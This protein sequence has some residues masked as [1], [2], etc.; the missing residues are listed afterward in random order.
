[1]IEFLVVFLLVFVLLSSTGVFVW[2]L[3]LH[4]RVTKL[5]ETQERNHHTLLESISSLRREIAKLRSG[6]EIQESPPFRPDT[7]TSPNI[8]AS[9][10]VKEIAS[11]LKS[12]ESAAWFDLEERLGANW[13]LKLGMAMVVIGIAL[14]L[15]YTFQRLGPAGK[16]LIGAVVSAACILGGT[17]IERS[18]KYIVFGR[19]IL[20]GGWALAYFTAYAMRHI[21]ATRVID[22][23][24]GGLI[25]MGIVSIGMIL[26]SL[27]Y[28]SEF[29]T[30]FAYGLAYLALMVSRVPWSGLV[31]AA[32]LSTSIAVITRFRKWYGIEIFA[33]AAT[34]VHHF[35]WLY[36]ILHSMAPERTAF[37]EFNVSFAILI[38]YW[39]I[40]TLSHFITRA[41]VA[42]QDRYGQ[43]SM[44]LNAVG[45]AGLSVY[46]SF[47][48]E[49]SFRFFLILGLVYFVVAFYSKLSKRR[50]DFLTASTIGALLLFIAVPY[51]FSGQTLIL[52]WLLEIEFFLVTG[53]LLQE[54][55]FRRIAWL[56]TFPFLL[57]HMHEQF[58]TIPRSASFSDR[59]DNAG[60]LAVAICFLLNALFLAAKYA[61]QIKTVTE[62][63]TPILY[64]TYGLISLLNYIHLEV[65]SDW[66]GIAWSVVILVLVAAGYLLKSRTLALQAI[67]LTVLV[68]LW[69]LLNGLDNPA[70]R[71]FRTVIVAG[72]FLA[73]SFISRAFEKIGSQ[74]NVRQRHFTEEY[75]FFAAVA[76]VTALLWAET[77]AGYLTA[78][79][80]IEGVWVFL[81]AI[82]LDR[83]SYRLLG[84]GILLL[85][86]CK[87]LFLDVWNLP[88][89]QRI[90]TFIVLGASLVLI[91]FLYTKYKDVWRKILLGKA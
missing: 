30:G 74:K 57:Y 44:I 55:Q 6:T 82:L 48:Q 33:V 36:P 3:I 85:C 68:M 71:I 31:A 60:L 79:W 39:S 87:I 12:E 63:Q 78:A 15:G 5:K 11:G 32:V 22:T 8:F 75:Y 83:R 77:R 25:T 70:E 20:S 47:N 2:L 53:Y 46:Q 9:P 66:L 67:L 43:M 58:I 62:K 72:I 90:V 88:T 81:T 59:F 10:Q 65:I 49:W 17:L 1:M 56:T 4:S 73:C 29:F 64:S 23:N 52:L 14:F 91:S 61:E 18:R 26:Y 38:C 13:L 42:I 24:A 45:F 35:I 27:K 80:A 84:L 51:K 41:N 54:I 89:F 28:N 37:A 16:I 86:T 19:V 21:E 7:S 34:Y 76:V 69:C 50:N 40:F